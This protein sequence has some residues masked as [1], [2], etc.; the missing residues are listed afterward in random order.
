[1][2]MDV[3]EAGVRSCSQGMAIDQLLRQS[4]LVRHRSPQRNPKRVI[5][6]EAHQIILYVL[7]V[8]AARAENVDPTDGDLHQFGESN[9]TNESEEGVKTSIP[10]QGVSKLDDQWPTV[11]KLRGWEGSGSHPDFNQISPT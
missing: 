1:M 2:L 3:A 8:L 10:N 5:S 11:K 9:S 6:F 7:V 4:L